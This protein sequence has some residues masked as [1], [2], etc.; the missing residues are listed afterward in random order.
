M[1][2]HNLA[3][4]LEVGSREQALRWHLQSNHYPPISLDFIGVAEQAIEDVD[5]GYLDNEILMPNGRTLTAAAIVDGLHLG[6]FLAN[7]ADEDDRW[8]D[9]DEEDDE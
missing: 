8:Y 3:G 5:C 9:A 4:M 2:S 1:G 6:Q 7:D